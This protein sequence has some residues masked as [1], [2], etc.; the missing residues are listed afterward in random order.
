MHVKGHFV[1]VPAT[2][3]SG[4]KS[5][6]LGLCSPLITP[7]IKENLIQSNTLVFK[8]VHSLDMKFLELTET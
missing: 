4:E 1:S 6:F 2:D 3:G 5:V 7:D 8:S